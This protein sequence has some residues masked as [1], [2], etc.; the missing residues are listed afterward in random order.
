M[1]RPKKQYC[2]DECYVINLYIQGTI[3]EG[4]FID[5]LIDDDLEQEKKAKKSFKN[6]TSKGLDA[7]RVTN[8]VYQW[9]SEKGVKRLN[10]NLRQA[11]Y[12]Q[13]NK[14]KTLK[15]SQGL[16]SSIGAGARANQKSI[17]AYLSDLVKKEIK[18][19]ALK[20]YQGEFKL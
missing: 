4:R 17:E 12:R 7:E 2:L 13:D 20:E 5:L 14:I 6:M 16:I 1:S 3:K 9:L 8:W 19:N 10:S 18:E 11:K 15:L